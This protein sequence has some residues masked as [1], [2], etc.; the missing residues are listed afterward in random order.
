MS[1]FLRKLKE[2]VDSGKPNESIN[3]GFNEILSRADK[4]ASDPEAL[5]QVKEKYE[6]INEQEGKELQ[7]TLTLEEVEKLNELAKL[8]EQKI[9]ET[10]QKALITS[11]VIAFNCEIEK[12][13]L[14]IASKLEVVEEY[15]KRRLFLQ[16]D[17]PYEEKKAIMDKSIEDFNRR[18]H[19]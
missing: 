13:E 9:F 11:G 17:A 2:A 12:I 8:Q 3:A 14:E 4:I 16:G 6:K 7:K 18:R 5:K 1:D 15:K 10:E 19:D